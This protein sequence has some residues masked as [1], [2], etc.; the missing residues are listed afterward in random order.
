MPG[1]VTVI[2]AR[3]DFGRSGRM[4][5]GV[6]GTTAGKVRQGTSLDLTLEPG[7][8]HFRI[9]GGAGRSKQVALTVTEGSRQHLHAGIHPGLGLLAVMAGATL[10]YV[11]GPLA[12]L[13]V[14]LAFFA[15]PGSWFYLRTSALS[16]AA[17]A[18]DRAEDKAAD[19]APGE[20]WWLS[21]PNLAKRYRKT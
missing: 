13:P 14:I 7:E 9:S 1:T 10:A 12:A 21:D 18:L 6:D 8:H 20:P 3:A 5:V 2:A 17:E 16:P 11:G 4:R 15:I 19:T